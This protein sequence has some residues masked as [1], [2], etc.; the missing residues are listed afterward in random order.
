MGWLCDTDHWSS[1]PLC[2]VV[3][4]T[5]TS[6]H[7]LFLCMGWLCDTDHWSSSLGVGWLC[8]IDH[9]SSSLAFWG[10]VRGGVLC[11]GLNT[12]YVS[13]SLRFG[14]NTGYVFMSLC[15][16][17]LFLSSPPDGQFH[18]GATRFVPGVGLPRGHL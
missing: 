4:M 5:Q 3:C 13:I 2:G 14:L 10:A 8:N 12:G 15:S 17:D 9:W 16:V 6:G 18:R 11:F 1:F 7:L